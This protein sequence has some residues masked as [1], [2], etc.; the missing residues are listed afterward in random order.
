MTTA[1]VASVTIA[2]VAGWALGKF[3]SAAAETAFQL[4]TQSFGKLLPLATALAL[5]GGMSVGAWQA[6]EAIF[7]P[8]ES[9]DTPYA[10]EAASQCSPCGACPI[11][12]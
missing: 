6:S 9:L 1:I 7:I 2:F 10:C 12:E 3:A 5:A 8:E 4:P 11:S